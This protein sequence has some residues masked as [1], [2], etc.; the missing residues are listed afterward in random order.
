MRHLPGALLLLVT[1]TFAHAESAP[2]P[3][4]I[5]VAA[6]FQDTF[7]TLAD[8]YR[9]RSHEQIEASY[10][11]TGALYDQIMGGAPFAALFGAD[12]QRSAQLVDAKRARPASRFIYAIG[13]LVLW[14]PGATTPPD[15]TWLA[16][17]THRI[18]IADPTVAP[19][20]LAAQQTLAKLSLWDTVGARLVVGNDAAQTLQTIASGKAAGGFV[21]E[22]QLIAH[23]HTKPPEAQVWHVPQTMHAPIIQEAVA[24]NGPDAARAEEFFA[25]VASDDGRA[26]IEAAGYSVLAP[27]KTTTP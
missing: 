14:A 21:A 18:A 2:E 24:L 6:N 7:V 26:I 20:G 15:P 5:A 16:D 27:V 10:G 19:Y 3:L 23:F 25:F 11:A 13:H 1:A 4:R 9:Q 22:A 17:T 12:D 8:A